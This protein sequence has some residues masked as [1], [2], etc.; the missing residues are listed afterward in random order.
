MGS[1]QIVRWRENTEVVYT[2]SF[3]EEGMDLKIT[4]GLHMQS[5]CNI[6]FLNV[7]M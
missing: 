2:A 7:R 6:V 5:L 3:T 4:Y 1:Y